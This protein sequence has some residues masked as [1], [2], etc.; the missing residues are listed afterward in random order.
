[1]VLFKE[2]TGRTMMAIAVVLQILGYY[3]MKR[4][5]IIKLF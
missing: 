3:A 5:M 4:I 1:M 2:E